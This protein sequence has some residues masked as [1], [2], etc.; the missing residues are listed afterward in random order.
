MSVFDGFTEASIISDDV[1]DNPNLTPE[2]VAHLEGLTD[3]QLSEALDD[4]VKLWEDEI[5]QILD[6]LRGTAIHRLLDAA[7][8]L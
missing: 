2:Q 4:A 3:E 1:V 7:G 5:F 8:L 6:N